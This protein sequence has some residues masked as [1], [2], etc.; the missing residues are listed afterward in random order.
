MTLL[1]RLSYTC[2]VKRRVASLQ[3]IPACIFHREAKQIA[4]DTF[5]YFLFPRRLANPDITSAVLSPRSDGGSEWNWI[6]IFEEGLKSLQEG[7]LSTARK[8]ME[9][10]VESRGGGDGPAEFYLRKI[11]ALQA[12][13]SEAWDGV[14]D[15][16]EK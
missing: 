7:N 15:L 14:V 10:I 8:A 2:T 3:I 1:I 16:S 4:V 9:R 6:Q 13:G 11:A 5:V 12:D